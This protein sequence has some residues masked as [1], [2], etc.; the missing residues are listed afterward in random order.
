MRIIKK[1]LTFNRNMKVKKQL[2]GIYVIV[3]LIPILIIGVQL[4]TLMCNMVVDRAI[5]EACVNIERIKERLNE[6]IKIA[7]S[8][9]ESIYVDGKIAQVLKTQ[10]EDSAQIV[11]TY[12]DLTII[13]TYLMHYEEISSIRIYND[14]L[15]LLNNSQFVRATEDIKRSDW[16]QA[17]LARDSQMEWHLKYDEIRKQYYMSLIRALRDKQKNLLGV[18]VINFDPEKINRIIKDEPY[19]TMITINGQVVTTSGNS[20][21][22]Y[23]QL[24]H[25]RE[26]QVEQNKNYKI[27]VSNDTG[28]EYIIFTSFTPAKTFNSQVEICM[29]MSVNSITGETLKIVRTSLA[30]IMISLGLSGIL[31]LIFSKGFSNRIILVRK[32]MHKVSLGDFNI[33]KSIEGNDE[34]GE[35]YED[36]CQTVESVKQ[37][38]EENY[39]AKVQKEELKRK[40]KEMQFEMLSSQINPH[41][42][43]NTLETIRMK[44][45]C[46]GE[47]ELAGVVKK[48][49]KLLRRNLE[50]SDR[51]VSLASELEMIEAYLTI[52][53]FRFGERISYHIENEIESEK[54]YLLPLLLQ[55]IVENAFIHGLEAKQGSGKIVC[56][57]KE[58]NHCLKIAISDNGLGISKERLQQIQRSL[59][60][61]Q[62]EERNRV[63]LKNINERIK[64]Y[65]GDMYGI[66][67]ESIED[68]GTTVTIVLPKMQEG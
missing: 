24:D 51:S 67:I 49:S 25:L 29:S 42:L 33:R 30:M 63:G 46:N 8:V 60:G 58:Q 20:D 62:I 17:A 57:I 27:K 11:N 28:A 54:Y 43:Y 50:V 12:K 61:E 56:S 2:I 6:K 21:P 5:N 45:Y 47:T 65:Y 68:Q 44:A 38:I 59:H 22:L 15:T 55:P 40:Q 13:S 26:L 48:L 32:E 35:L 23:E 3:I 9:A 4:T 39:S 7:N 19:D 53:K 64:L 36:I 66:T 31:I 18:L 37:L 10:F 34:I 41:F 16:Y 1:I 52:Q 14:N